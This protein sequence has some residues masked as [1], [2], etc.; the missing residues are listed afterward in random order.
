MNAQGV[1]DI[2]A[3]H[4]AAEDR[5]IRFTPVCSH[6]AIP[7]CLNPAY[8]G[9]LSV[10]ADALAPLL[11]QLAGLP[12]APTRLLQEA[13]TFRQDSGNEVEIRPAGP[14]IGGAAG[15]ASFVLPVQFPGPSRTPAQLAGQL[16]GAYAP[17]LVARVVEDRAGAS[18]AQNAVAR[19]LLTAAGLHDPADASAAGN[20]PP[21]GGPD[22]G[23]WPVVTPGTPAYAASERFAALPEAARHAWLVRNLAALRAGRITPEQLP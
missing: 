8:S 22:A 10:T 17:D 2:P 9:Y 15:S 12:S 3:L 19:A 14:G 5:P 1:I 13:V 18:Q 23:P 11:D 7:V 4:N 16:V 6:T 20:G 21:T